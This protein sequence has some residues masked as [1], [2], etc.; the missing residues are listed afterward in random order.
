MLTRAERYIQL[1]NVTLPIISRLTFP[2]DESGPDPN[3]NMT[4]P[5][6]LLSNTRFY[7]RKVLNGL[8][9]VLVLSAITLPYFFY[10]KKTNAGLSLSL[11]H[12]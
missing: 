5:D 6:S 1:L 3:S 8:V 10:V 11:I 7:L 2:R 9:I 12:I 4:T